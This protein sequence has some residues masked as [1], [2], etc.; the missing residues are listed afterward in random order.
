MS[1]EKRK[2]FFSSSICLQLYAISA[3]SFL[4]TKRPMLVIKPCVVLMES[5]ET[6]NNTIPFTDSRIPFR[7]LITHV[8]ILRKNYH[9]NWVSE[10]TKNKSRFNSINILSWTMLSVIIMNSR[11]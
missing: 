3:A 9:N 7:I 2:T 1:S 11:A 6:P 5:L 10:S 4:L 8:R